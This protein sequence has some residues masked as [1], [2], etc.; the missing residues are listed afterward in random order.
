M[1]RTVYF[2]YSLCGCRDKILKHQHSHNH[3]DVHH[4]HDHENGHHG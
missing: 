2:I 1:Y 3:E 4:D